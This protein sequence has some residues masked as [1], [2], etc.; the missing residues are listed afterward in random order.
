MAERVAFLYGLLYRKHKEFLVK[1]LSL[2]QLLRWE[3]VVATPVA[4]LHQGLEA[5]AVQV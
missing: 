1:F 4:K 3:E 2:I 5:W